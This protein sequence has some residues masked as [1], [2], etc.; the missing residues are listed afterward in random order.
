MD[1]IVSLTETKIKQMKR[2]IL[3]CVD[4]MDKEELEEFDEYLTILLKGK[5]L[6]K[7]RP[8]KRVFRLIS[9]HKNTPDSIN[10]E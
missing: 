2:E 10:G 7:R 5:K 8:Q 6:H 3:D 4:E 9:F 1:N